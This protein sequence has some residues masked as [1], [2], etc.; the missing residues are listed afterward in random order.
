MLYLMFFP[1]LNFI[2]IKIG[3][4]FLKFLNSKDNT[5]EEKRTALRDLYL[6]SQ[7]LGKR[8]GFISKIQT[9]MDKL[10]DEASELARKR[11]WKAVE[12]FCYVIFNPTVALRNYR[13]KKLVD[14]ILSENRQKNIER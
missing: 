2:Y 11:R 14:R 12:R 10:S 6:Q 1:T 13:N 9:E 5:T 7:E 8:D 4:I 3:E